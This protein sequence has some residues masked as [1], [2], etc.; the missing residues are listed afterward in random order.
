MDVTTLV[1]FAAAFCTSVSYYPQL[2]KCW[3]SGS[4]G[5]LS[6]TMFSTLA[7]GVALWVVYGFLQRDM[8]IVL[9]N[10]V[11]FGLLC[12]ILYVKLR[13]PCERRELRTQR[14]ERTR[15]TPR[16]QGGRRRDIIHLSRQPR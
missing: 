16:E 1:G 12:G 15:R 11:S 3:Q 5:D 9:A 4:A 2:R 10:V 6:L 14:T 13:E 7:T 8:V